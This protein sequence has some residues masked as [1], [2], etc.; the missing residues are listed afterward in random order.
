MAISALVLLTLPAQ[1]GW[2]ANAARPFAILGLSGALA[3]AVLPRMESLARH[4]LRRLSAPEALRLKLILAME[5]GLRGGSALF[6]TRS[7]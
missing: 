4:L 2:L 1:P 5:H 6:T 7:V 3:I